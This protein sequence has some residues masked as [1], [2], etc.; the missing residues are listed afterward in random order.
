MSDRGKAS[1]S[2]GLSRMK[3]DD[4]KAGMKGLDKEKINQ[5]ILEA[6]KGSKFYENERK[7]EKQTEERLKS[8]KERL[9]KLTDGD[10][11]RA[12]NK[13]DKIIEEMEEMRD[14]SRTI[15]H[16]DMDMFYAAVEMRNNP[17]LRDK[18]VTVGGNSMLID[19]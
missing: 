4:Q 12:L 15:V 3:L 5:I 8:L 18:S 9:S 10:K 6:S 13:V 17:L 2:C 16:V 1:S 7:K 19:W 11:K 14:M